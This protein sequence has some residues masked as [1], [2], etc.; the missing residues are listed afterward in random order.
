MSELFLLIPYYVL[1]RQYKQESE[2]RDLSWIVPGAVVSERRA[3]GVSSMRSLISMKSSMVS[4]FN[5]GGVS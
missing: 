3:T 5:E 2:L 1:F 4:V